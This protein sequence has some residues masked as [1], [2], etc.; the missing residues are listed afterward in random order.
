M[1][2][3]LVSMALATSVVLAAEHSGDSD[4]VQRTINFA[5]FAGIMYYL[6]GD[7]VKAYF[8][9][10]SQGIEQELQKVQNRLKEAKMAKIEADKKLEDAARIASDIL[11]ISKKENAMLNEKISAQMENDLVSIAA[12]H[13]SLISFEQREMVGSLVEEIMDDVLSDE[14]IPLDNEV[15][16]EIMLKKVA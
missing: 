13:E 3:Y 14:N 11:A 12:Q 8:A 1:I 2:K 16:T 7:K 6:I 15:I 10:R 9:D 4:I 5:V